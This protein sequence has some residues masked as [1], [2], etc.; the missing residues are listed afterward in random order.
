MEYRIYAED[1]HGNSAIYTGKYYIYEEESAE[2]T[3][4]KT[5]TSIT[6]TVEPKE[7]TV[8]EEVTIKGSI[9]P[10]MSTLI[11]LTIKRPDG[12]T[13]TKT[14]TSGADGSFSFNVILDMEGEWTFTADFAGDHEHE[15]STSTPVIV[16]VKSPGSTTTPLHY[17]II[18]VAVITAIII[19]VV[20]IKKK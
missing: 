8:G 18:P 14:V 12:T 20:L 19:A 11:T 3:T 10:A 1:I 17:V 2:S 13:K 7:V 16:K 9:S 15:P 4:G 5:P 6:I